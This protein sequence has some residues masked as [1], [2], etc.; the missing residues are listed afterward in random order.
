MLEE[1]VK[2]NYNARFDTHS[3]HCCREWHSNAR[4]DVKSGQSYSSAMSRSRALGHS[5]CSKS[6]LRTITL[7]WSD[8]QSYHCFR[9]MHLNARLD[10]KS[11]Q[12]HLSSKSR[13]RTPVHSACLKG[14]SRTITMQSMTL[15]SMTASEKG[16]LMLDST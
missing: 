14:M 3:Y 2:V 16:T 9:E 10:V 4:L 15:A 7:Q 5:A 13:S 12:S 8:T 6:M 11:G 1:Y